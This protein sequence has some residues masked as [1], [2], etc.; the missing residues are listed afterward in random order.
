[1]ILKYDMV[2]IPERSLSFRSSGLARRKA[3]RRKAG[4][5]T[6]M[7]VARSAGVSP[8]TVSRV[9]NGESNVREST[10]KGVSDA[11]SKLGYTPNLAARRLAGANQIC[12]G[13]LY[14]QPRASYVSAFLLGSLLQ[15]SRRDVQLLA[16]RCETLEDGLA[17]INQFSP[18]RID[19][20]ILPPPWSD[21][22]DILDLLES[23]D[24]STVVVATGNPRT[25]CSA[26]GIDDFAAS[27]AMV[28]HLLELGH[29]RIGFICGKPEQAASR[30]RQRGYED[31]LTNAGLEIDIDLIA[32]G[33]FTY[34][35]GLEAAR[36][37]L[38]LQRRPTAIFASN[39][40]MAAGASAYAHRVGID[41]PAD[42]SV[43]GFDNTVIAETVWPELTTI[44]Q[45]IEEMSRVAIDHLLAKI[46]AR[47]N[48]DQ[49]ERKHIVL[50]YKFV[51]RNSDA[52]PKFGVIE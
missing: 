33:R 7:D 32:P 21:S 17:A 15:A 18:G 14:D 46:R 2:A 20:V 27:R 1:M 37:L 48:G 13:V 34:R 45:P 50:D 47:R 16:E 5:P 36:Q 6:I 19:G 42:L 10:R 11:I 28:D 8:M 35:S 12:I 49:A 43:C 52:P 40:D 39:D 25:T 26:V 9:I 51:R 41:I 24:L 30:R 4:V 44:D 29:K 38:S 3:T 23:R 22:P 31:A